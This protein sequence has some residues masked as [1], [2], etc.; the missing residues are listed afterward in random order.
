MNVAIGK[1]ALG[2]F[3]AGNGSV[4]TSAAQLPGRLVNKHVVIRAG[5]DNG[6]VVIVGHS[7]DAVGA[8]FVLAAGEQT[9]PIYVDDLSK[10]WI[11]G[12]AASQAFSWL[13]N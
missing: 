5:S 13:V 2:S 3:A 9:P 11:K 6:N 7:A 1:E 12:G 4:G 8:G 10:L